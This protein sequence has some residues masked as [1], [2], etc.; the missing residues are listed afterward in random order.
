MATAHQQR[1]LKPNVDPATTMPQAY[2]I[3]GAMLDRLNL[4]FVGYKA[5]LSSKPAQSAFN[6][7]EPLLGVLLANA[8][9]EGRH[10]LSQMVVPVIEVEM[11]YEL[12]VDVTTEVSIEQFA[13]T[14]S[15]LHIAIDLAEVG[16]VGK[17]SAVDLVSGNS[18]GGSY[19]KGPVLGSAE[20]N[21][22]QVKLLK[23]G[24]VINEATSG[25]IGDQKALAIWLVNKALS[26][27]YPL[28]KGMF[29]M[30]GA[31]GTILGAKPG[32]YT[33]R[34]ESEGQLLA[35]VDVELTQ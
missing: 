9:V 18:A 28:K 5:V 3:Q 34:Y 26:L 8:G 35:S 13:E 1:Q 30:S 21:H 6:V 25:D 20:P 31:L 12:G 24:D 23:D 11:G 32:H 7:T 16:Y 33:A 14:F 22:I 2:Q 27:N 10:D 4:S 29:L 15:Q 17:A 19:I